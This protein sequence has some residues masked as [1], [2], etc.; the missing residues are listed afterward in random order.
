[1]SHVCCTEKAPALSHGG[2]SEMP[3]RHVIDAEQRDH[4]ADHIGQRSRKSRPEYGLPL[5][6]AVRPVV[7]GM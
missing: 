4:Q 3:M 5:L 7:P 6:L 1:M 2:Y